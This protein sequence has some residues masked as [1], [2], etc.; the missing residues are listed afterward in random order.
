MLAGMSMLTLRQYVEYEVTCGDQPPR[1]LDK[2]RVILSPL[3]P[4]GD[5]LLTIST[6]GYLILSYDGQCCL[7]TGDDHRPMA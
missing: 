6:V 7:V 1:T 5:Y 2:R 3:N 4:R